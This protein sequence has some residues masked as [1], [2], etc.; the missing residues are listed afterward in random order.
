MSTGEREGRGGGE[1]RAGEGGTAGASRCAHRTGQARETC[2]AMSFL[3]TSLL[4]ASHASVRLP[5]GSWPNSHTQQSH[6][7]H[8]Q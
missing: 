8:T 3:T 4:H 5:Q 7:S 2:V 6:N 1:A